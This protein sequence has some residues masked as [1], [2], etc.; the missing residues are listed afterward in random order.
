MKV[1]GIVNVKVA[2]WQAAAY[3]Q[4]GDWI[5]MNMLPSPHYK[6]SH[7]S[8]EVGGWSA[9]EAEEEK[10]EELDL[11]PQAIDRSV[12]R[13]KS[14]RYCNNIQCNASASPVSSPDG[15]GCLDRT[16]LATRQWQE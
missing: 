12:D 15:P 7:G 9:E 2:R 13:I 10:E 8:H 1:K 3:A 6:V 5:R 4:L 16:L 11:Q 14:T